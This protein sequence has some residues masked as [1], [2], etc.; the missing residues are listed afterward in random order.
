MFMLFSIFICLTF[1]QVYFFI[2]LAVLPPVTRPF[3]T[4]PLVR[5]SFSI[6]LSLA[7]LLYLRPSLTRNYQ[8]H[9]CTCSNLDGHRQPSPHLLF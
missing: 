3:L 5:R 7:F 6:Y 8:L 1:P 4:Q 9:E 2:G